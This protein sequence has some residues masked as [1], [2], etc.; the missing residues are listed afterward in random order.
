[1]FIKCDSERI[2]KLLLL[3]LVCRSV[4]SRG[5]DSTTA[6]AHTLGRV[7]S[8]ASGTSHELAGVAV[9]VVVIVVIAIFVSLFVTCSPVIKAIHRIASGVHIPI[10][11]YR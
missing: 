11:A 10:P 2:R 6:S 8:G 9:V 3:A 5:L 7:G 4:E 1:E